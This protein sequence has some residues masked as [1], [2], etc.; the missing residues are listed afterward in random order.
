MAKAKKETASLE[1]MLE[2]AVVKEDERPY[3]VL[4]NWVWT[5]LSSG[6]T[7]CLDNFRKPINATE[8]A[9]R[10][11]DIPYYGATGQ[12]GWIDDYLTDEQLVLVG[13]DGA[14]FLEHIKDKAYII[15]GKAWVNNHAHILKSLY[16]EIGNKYLMHYLNIFDYRGYVNG[17]T[18][19][20]LTQASMNTIPI[21]LPPLAEQQRIVE[22]IE[23]L[24][25]KLD[26]AKE[27]V[28]NAL[29]SF[30]NHKAAILHKA[31]TGELSAKWREENGVS[32][33]SWK[34]RLL[35]NVVTGFKYGVS[36]K[37]DYLNTGMPVIRIPN[38]ISNEIDFNDMKYL[39]NFDIP[40]ENQI[41]E[42]DILIIRS[43]GS[44]DIVGK[45]ALVGSLERPYTFASYLIR[46]RPQNI[47]PKYLLQLLN[48]SY[49]RKQLFDKARSSAGINN[50]NSKELGSVEIPLPTRA[51]QQE[52][53]RLLDTL[54]EKEQR[55]K[56]VCDVIEKI[57]HMKKAILAR[58]FRG[59]LGTNNPEE[60]SAVGLLKEVLKERL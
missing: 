44:R 4:G 30:E 53:V 36:E 46:I 3:E 57:D 22:V 20:K 43:N 58:A 15:E 27:L 49:V 2:Q 7:Q 55:A 19:L 48:S 34:Q 38:V 50:I 33:D 6:F 59:E 16:G 51:E 28:Q 21:P 1:E 10:E 40:E 47:E 54:F 60:E 23:S 25:E 29:D 9:N 35:E 42:N 32:F 17:T 11:G 45:C 13:E 18:R 8:R 5:R 39:N 26:T 41:K 56:E 52:I 14:P 37:S 31:F 12:V 24:F